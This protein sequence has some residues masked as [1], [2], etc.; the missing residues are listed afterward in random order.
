MGGVL[1]SSL[2]QAAVL[3]GGQ[4]AAEG[5]AEVGLQRFVGSRSRTTDNQTLANA[6]VNSDDSVEAA[7]VSIHNSISRCLALTADGRDVVMEAFNG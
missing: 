7:V 1:A 2:G 4:V 5:L 3:I 6:N